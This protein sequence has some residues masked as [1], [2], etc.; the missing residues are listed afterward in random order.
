MMLEVLLA[1][2]SVPTSHATGDVDSY[3]DRHVFVQTGEVSANSAIVNA[4]CNEE[5]RSLVIITYSAVDRHAMMMETKGYAL[6][7]YDYTVSVELTRL[8]ANTLYEYRVEC[9]PLDVSDSSM[10]SAR[11]SFYTAPE[12]DDAKA[13]SFVWAADLAGQV[14][15]RN[16][17]L[18]IANREGT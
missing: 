3:T 13:V 2:L 16:P 18:A 10:S 11:G 15:G 1:L 12:A 5:K 6:P 14:W 17:Q 7:D 4:R 9:D 8:V